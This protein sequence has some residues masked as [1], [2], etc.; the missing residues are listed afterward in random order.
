MQSMTPTLVVATW[1]PGP[2]GAGTWAYARTAAGGP[3]PAGKPL[4]PYSNNSRG[5]FSLFFFK[6]NLNFFK[7]IF[8]S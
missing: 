7:L 1:Q 4:L 2:I 8:F 6:K 3:G 5:L